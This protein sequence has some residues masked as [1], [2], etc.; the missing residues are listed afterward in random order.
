MKRKQIAICLVG[1]LLIGKVAQADPVDREQA[2]TVATNFARVANLNINLTPTKGAED[3][4]SGQFSNFYV[5]TGSNGRGFVIVSA[6]DCTTP[7]LGYSEDAPFVFDSMPD[8]IREWLQGYEDEI[9]YYRSHTPRAGST[10]SGL[11]QELLDMPPQPGMGTAKTGDNT[12]VQPLLQ[13]QW[14]QVP[15]YNA[16]CPRHN[17]RRYC[18]ITENDTDTLTGSI[19]TVTGC[20]ATATAQVM[21]YWNWPPHGRGSNQYSYSYDEILIYDTVIDGIAQAI[22]KD[23]T[24]RSYRKTLSATF[25]DT[26]FA[27]DDMPESLISSSSSSEVNAVATLMYNVGIALNMGYGPSSGATTINGNTLGHHTVEEVL[28]DYFYYSHTVASVQQQDFTEEE[29]KAMLRHELDAARPIVYKGRST[30]GSGHSFVCDGYDDNDMFHFNWGWGGY[31]DGY[32]PIGG[33]NPAPGGTG[34]ATESNY[35]LG[36]GAVIG[37]EPAATM[38]PETGTTTIIAT[39][40]NAAYGTVSGSGTYN[41]WTETVTMTA[42]PAEGHSFVG[43]SDGNRYNP[44]RL[45]ASGGC[46]TFTAIFKPWNSGNVSYCGS[47]PNYFSYYNDSDVP[48]WGIRI[49]YSMLGENLVLDKVSFLGYAGSYTIKVYSGGSTPSDGQLVYTSGSYSVNASPRIVNHTT[50][51][52]VTANEDVWV[53][54]SGS[55][56]RCITQGN[57]TNSDGRWEKDANGVWHNNSVS[58][59]RPYLISC[60]FSGTEYSMVEGLTV[61]SVN[62]TGATIS[63]SAPTDMTP[64]DYVL[65]YGT[66]YQ[67]EQMH[68]VTT[69]ANTYSLTGLE[70]NTEYRVFVK[71]CYG[72]NLRYSDWARATFTTTNVSNPVTITGYANDPALGF[73][74]GCGIYEAGSSVTLQATPMVGCVFVEWDDGYGTNPTRTLTANADGEYFAT[75]ERQGYTFTANSNNETLG[76]VEVEGEPSYT[77]EGT[78]YYP[79]LSTITLTAIPNGNARFS[80]WSDGNTTNPRYCT[81]M[82]NNPTQTAYFEAEAKGGV[83]YTSQGL[84]LSVNTTG[85]EPVRVYDMLGRQLY[86]CDPTSS[87]TITFTLPSAGVY[88]IRVGNYNEKIIIR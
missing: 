63:W 18:P 46:Q 65:A 21:K 78:N 44:R 30:S 77:I 79:F 72:S 40:N 69:T 17:A 73:V 85:I 6:D 56:K 36:G 1:L 32:Y 58:S 64:S 11:W 82:E 24:S 14:D 10:T 74:A 60:Y 52:A 35:N 15:L 88:I 34:A 45:I 66:G 2:R 41:N 54:L 84:Q 53:T 9:A 5:F 31:C 7:I 70:A 38:Q 67:P 27:W 68:S 51:I 59:P 12:V 16:H 75:F 80:H 42:T 86:A 48:E 76:T 87:T 81:V 29:W 28:R 4:M 19:Q 39:A 26:T 37:I 50:N 22:S 8:H 20:V 13:T 62:G 49:P 43:W 3:P 23:N 83:S 61:T 25:A 71:A 47:F 57:I 55:G 33:L